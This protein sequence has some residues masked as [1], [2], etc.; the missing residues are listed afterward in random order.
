MRPRKFKESG[1]GLIMA[2]FLLVVLTGI[3]VAMADLASTQRAAIGLDAQAAYAN[4]AARAGIEWGRYE[5]LNS[6]SL[7]CPLPSNAFVPAAQSLSSF[8]VTV[9]CKSN[10]NTSATPKIIVVQLTS[11]AVAN[12]GTDEEVRRKVQETFE[13]TPTAQIIDRRELH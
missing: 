6:P 1:F 12:L 2:V 4:Q 3:A 9:T 7:D 13:S 11:E 5:I 10:T 8:T